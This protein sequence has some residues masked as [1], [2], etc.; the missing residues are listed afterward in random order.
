MKSTF[1]VIVIL[2][3]ALA[4][5]ASAHYIL[6]SPKTRGMIEEQQ[7]NPPC[8]GF[9]DVQAERTKWPMGN[10]IGITAYHANAAFSIFVSLSPKPMAMSDFTEY[11]SS[12]L[13][14]VGKHTIEFPLDK[15]GSEAFLKAMQVKE[16]RELAGKSATI[17]TRY[18]GGDGTLYQCGDVVF[19]AAASKQGQAAAGKSGSGSGAAAQVGAGSGG[20]VVA[21]A[22]A[23]AGLF[24]V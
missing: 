21:A 7:P 23:A 14:R 16:V 3:A 13:D 2:A 11:S 24:A 9:N 5:V 12:R 17:M 22:V 20:V 1:A 4:H 18:D 10:P 8:G 15:G 19:E 6:T